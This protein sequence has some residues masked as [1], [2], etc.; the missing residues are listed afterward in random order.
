MLFKIE[1]LIKRY[2]D[3][4]VWGGWFDTLVQD[5]VGVS[6]EQFSLIRI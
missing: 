3:I 1:V 2:S 5:R 6:N 4:L